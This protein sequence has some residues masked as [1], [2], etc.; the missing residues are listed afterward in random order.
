MP[1]FKCEYSIL[2]FVN[3]PVRFE[4]RNVGVL[5]QCPDI[6]YF[7]GLFTSE[8]RR[9]L[10]GVAEAI[11]IEIVEEYFAEFSR[12]FA[13]AKKWQTGPG[14]LFEPPAYLQKGF[15]GGLSENGYDKLLF[16]PPKGLITQDLS[17]DLRKLY[18]RFVAMPQPLM[19]TGIEK[20]SSES[21]A[22]VESVLHERGLIRRGGVRARYAVEVREHR[23]ACD[24]GYK[25]RREVLLEVVDLTSDVFQVR[26]R[27]FSP[28]AIKFKLVK[29]DRPNTSRI[30]LLKTPT[31]SNGDLA[32]EH[33]T[34]RE[35][36]TD[37]IDLDKQQKKFDEL[38]QRIERETVGSRLF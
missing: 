20:P 34:L 17:A 28:S 27:H 24:F 21:R 4:P 25:T 5:L 29:E 22:L 37:L 14:T 1:D 30:A 6:S 36:A 8:L 2:Q 35:F 10:A 9:K 3:D 18:E 16:T 32:L 12:K 15:L 33:N 11:D 19:A 13:Q 38:L 31:T 26:L 23:F 7:D